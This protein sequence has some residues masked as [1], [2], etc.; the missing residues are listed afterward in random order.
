MSL[1][2]YWPGNSVVHQ[3]GPGIKIVALVALSTLL[4][5]LPRLDLA[6]LVLAAAAV[7]YRIAR[8]PPRAVFAQV[9][10]IAWLLAILFVAQIA[11]NGWATAFLVVLRLTGLVLLAA[12]VTLTTRA[13]ELIEALERG[14]GWLRVFGIAPAKASLAISLTLRFVPVLASITREVREAQRVRGLDRSLMAVAVP[15]LVRTL[16]MADDIADAIEARSYKLD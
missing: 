6:G 1:G 3:V 16:K 12:L 8:V 5:L 7:L 10:P 14:L 15:V 11:L 4:F 2:A 9:R 13:S